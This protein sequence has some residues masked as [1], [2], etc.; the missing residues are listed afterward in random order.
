VRCKRAHGCLADALFALADVSVMHQRHSPHR[1]WC[2]GAESIMARHLLCWSH[3]HVSW[4]LLMLHMR[5]VCVLAARARPLVNTCL[6]PFIRLPVHSKSNRLA[7]CQASDV[8]SFQQSAIVQWCLGE[9]MVAWQREA[10]TGPKACPSLTAPP[11]AVSTVKTDV[12]QLLLLCQIRGTAAALH[13]EHTN[14]ESGGALPA[15]CRG[16]GAL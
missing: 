16:R 6:A 9:W 8:P 4:V 13:H 11:C 3:P 10:M 14:R 7:K 2:C 5:S 12:A 15:G 1:A